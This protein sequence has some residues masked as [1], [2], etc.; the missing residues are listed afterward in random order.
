LIAGREPG[1][2]AGFEQAAHQHVGH[3]ALQSVADLGASDARIAEQEQ[4]E[5]VVA[6]LAG[7][8]RRRLRGGPA[9]QR[10]VRQSGVGV[11][12]H[13]GSALDQPALLQLPTGRRQ[14]EAAP[15]RQGCGQPLS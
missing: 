9:R 12:D 10:P 6:L 5:A 1:R 11:H 4:R 2:E 7:P 14:G 3:D 13:L 8:P 15:F